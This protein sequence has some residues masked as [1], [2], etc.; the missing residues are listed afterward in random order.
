MLTDP[1]PGGGEVIFLCHNH[2]LTHGPL[3][4]CECKARLCRIT[5]KGAVVL[6]APGKGGWSLTFTASTP[7][8]LL[9][10]EPEDTGQPVG[11]VPANETMFR[12]SNR[13]RTTLS[14]DCQP[15]GHDPLPSRLGLLL[16]A[17]LCPQIPTLNC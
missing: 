16:W 11:Q 13:K 15:L 3:D 7:G 10:T 17:E 12:G 6:P 5:S 2:C 9:R 8:F 1:V 14:Q 4:P